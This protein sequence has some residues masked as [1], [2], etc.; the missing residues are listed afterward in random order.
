[1]AD[2]ATREAWTTRRVTTD[3]GMCRRFLY[4][5]REIPRPPAALIRALLWSASGRR[6]V[7]ALRIPGICGSFR[8]WRTGTMLAGA[9]CT[10]T[11]FRRR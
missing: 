7:R 9:G 11:S 2:R 3:P 10:N 6:G 8:P 1:M 4:G 5:N